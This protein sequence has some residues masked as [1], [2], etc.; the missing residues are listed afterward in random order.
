[1][2]WK[3]LDY[4]LGDI[5]SSME[6]GK[7]QAQLTQFWY[8]NRYEGLY[9]G[10]IATLSLSC[11]T[12]VMRNVNYDDLLATAKKHATARKC[13]AFLLDGDKIADGNRVCL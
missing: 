9:A 1:M 3:Q 12:A 6:D 13:K 7:I 5:G 8:A 4:Q 11:A 10:V 2:K